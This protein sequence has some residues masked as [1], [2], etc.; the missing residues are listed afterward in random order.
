MVQYELNTIEI[1]SGEM[2]ACMQSDDNHIFIV[3][4]QECE[5]RLADIQDKLEV[6]NERFQLTCELGH[7]NIFLIRTE[8]TLRSAVLNRKSEETLLFFRVDQNGNEHEFAH[9]NHMCCY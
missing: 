6:H 8:E 5:K 2:S 1:W 7:E 9:Y 4:C 3:V